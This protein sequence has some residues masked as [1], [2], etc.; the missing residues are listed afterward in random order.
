MVALSDIIASNE[1]IPSAL[2]KGLVAVFVG[3]TSGVGEY[4]LK[5]F[6]KYAR[7]PR[8]LVIGRSQEAADRILAEC[9][10]LSPGGHFEFMRADVSLLKNIDD[11]CRQI[12]EKVSVINIL[13]QSQGTM[14]FNTKTAEGLP[15]AFSLPTHSRARFILNLL[16]LLQRADSLRRVVSVGA[17]TC[18]GPIDLKDISGWGFPLRRWRDQVASVGTLLLE[19]AQR[20]APDVAFI[21][22]VPGIV[23]SGILRDVQP[24]LRLSIIIGISRL[25]APL[26]NTPPVECGERHLF[27]ATSAAFA[28]SHGTSHTGV[29]VDGMPF[30]VA[31]GTDGKAGS[32]VYSLSQKLDPAG[33]K[34]LDILQQLRE[35]GTADNVWNYIAEDFRRITGSEVAL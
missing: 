9:R 28:P 10:Q 4:T 24:T 30:T 20:R 23:E 29:P 8:I 31:R 16:P 5:A 34:V 21:H 15:L 7:E 12:K 18:E 1:S 35:D 25:L 33:P 2:P 6:T 32:G 19:E 27:V 22:T 14:A 13:F 11:V 3:G 17:A 26:I